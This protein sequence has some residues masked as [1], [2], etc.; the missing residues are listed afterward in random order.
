MY[1]LAPRKVNI[2]GFHNEATNQQINYL[3]DEGQIIGKG[4]NA[5]LSMVFNSLEYFNQGEKH[6]KITCDNCGG[7][8]KNNLSL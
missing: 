7:Q 6:L 5:T 2:F 4:S 3:L 8:N 1:F